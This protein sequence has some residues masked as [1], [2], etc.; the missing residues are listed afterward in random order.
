MLLVSG[1]VESISLLLVFLLLLMSGQYC[2]WCVVSAA[3]R[4]AIIHQLLPCTPRASC[5]RRG[6]SSQC[7]ANSVANTCRLFLLV[8]SHSLPQLMMECR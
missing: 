5:G 6:R 7:R 2:K 4:W 8:S 1:E 3:G